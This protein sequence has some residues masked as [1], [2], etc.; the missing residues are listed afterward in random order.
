M[1]PLVYSKTY[2]LP[3]GITAEFS[4]DNGRLECAWSPDVPSV[5]QA[6]KLLPHY[7]AARNDF[8]GSLGMN[9]A[10]IEL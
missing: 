6:K 10:V 2:T 8:L 1:T 7:R 3:G 5:E 4:L 9:V